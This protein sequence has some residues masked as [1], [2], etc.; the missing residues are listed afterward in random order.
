MGSLT[1]AGSDRTLKMRLTPL[2]AYIVLSS[3][4]VNLINAQRGTEGGGSRLTPKRCTKV[5][6]SPRSPSGRGSTRCRPCVGRRCPPQIKTT[7][8][9]S[10]STSTSQPNNSTTRRAIPKKRRTTTTPTSGTTRSTST[11]TPKR[12]L[13]TK[14]RRTTPRTTGTSKA[15]RKPSK[16]VPPK[17]RRTTT[18]RPVSQTNEDSEPLPPDCTTDKSR[19]RRS[20]CPPTS[21]APKKPVK[22]SS[23]NLAKHYVDPALFNAVVALAAK[24]PP[25]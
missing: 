17:K 2:L 16:R 4:L 8:T 15:S 13:P 25:P 21:G 14:R 19:A 11:S 18:N 9:R 24:V 10:T 20:A 22:L 5:S 12:G 23:A 6:S 7:T 1:G 3:L